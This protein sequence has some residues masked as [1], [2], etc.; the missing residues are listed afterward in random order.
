MRILMIMIW[1]FTFLLVADSIPEIN[2]QL[3]HLKMFAKSLYGAFVFICAVVFCY[4]QFKGM[5]K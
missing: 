1:A 5:K 3:I 4:L 2:E